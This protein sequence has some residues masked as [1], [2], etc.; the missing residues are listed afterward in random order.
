MVSIRNLD[1]LPSISG[2]YLVHNMNSE[3]IYIG[4]SCN[5]RE[6]W[7]C[8]HHK[9]SEIISLYGTNIEISWAAIPKNRL[10]HAEYIAVKFYKPHLNKTTPSIV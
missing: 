10:N 7:K 6:R 3:V 9:M 8:G 1:Q 2:I 5:I 4:Q